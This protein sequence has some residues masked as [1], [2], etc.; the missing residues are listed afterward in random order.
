MEA[1]MK[2]MR[3]LKIY[4]EQV[5][6]F[7]PTPSTIST[8]LFYLALKGNGNAPYTATDGGDKL[9]QKEMFFLYSGR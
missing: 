6:D 7:T 9:K 3:D 4:P 2:T 5:Q 1:L 8:A